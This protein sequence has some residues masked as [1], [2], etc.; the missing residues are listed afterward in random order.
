VPYTLENTVIT[1]FRVQ[2]SGKSFVALV[3]IFHGS[4]FM[5]W[6]GDKVHK[7]Q[8][9]LELCFGLTKTAGQMYNYS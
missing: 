6:R 7:Q 2:S 8:F 9:V 1:L 5:V 4:Y 3:F